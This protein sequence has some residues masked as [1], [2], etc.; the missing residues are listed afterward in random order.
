MRV[1]DAGTG[2]ELRTFN[3]PDD[4]NLLVS[5]D[6]QT[7][8]SVGETVSVRSF[9]DGKER[10]AW[11]IRRA[12]K[13]DDPKTIR[14]AAVSPDGKTLAL[15]IWRETPG[16]E[17]FRILVCETDTGKLIWDG[18]AG[19]YPAVAL[20]FSPDGKTLASGGWRTTLW[21]AATGRIA[22][23]LDGHRGTVEALLFRADGKQLVS[24]GSDCTAVIWDLSK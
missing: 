21:D 7:L 20:A 11:K 2:K 5:R 3:G 9:A 6:N 4:G 10:A 15:G 18:W 8:V 17:R 16:D 19:M 22:R 23:T 14:G 24:G 1:F 12:L 13:I